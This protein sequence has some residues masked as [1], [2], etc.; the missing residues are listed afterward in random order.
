MRH[1]VHPM[2]VHFPIATWFI[3]TLCD[4]AS[5]FTT[6]ELVSR[7]AG[8]LLIIGTIS[9]L[10]AMVAGLMELAK[11]DQQSPAMKIANQHML[12]MM[13]S[14][15]LYTV[16]LFLRLDGTRLGQPGLA[17]VALSVLGLIVLCIAGWLGGKLV[18]EYGVGTRSNLS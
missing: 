18:Y 4:I 16:S 1:P 2:L 17:A 9:A 5:L 15:S 14:W 8:V 11:I 12:L 13:A 3:S 7:M 10:F 6:N